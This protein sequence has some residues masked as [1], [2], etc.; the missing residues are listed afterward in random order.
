MKKFFLFLISLLICYLL[1]QEKINQ[2]VNYK[3]L[4][5]PTQKYSHI[6]KVSKE[7]IYQGNL[8]LINK[9][10]KI[11]EQGVKSDIINLFQNKIPD[12]MVLSDNSM[13][14]SKD[15]A[16]NLSKMIDAA[17]LKGINHFMISSGYRNNSKQEKL[18]EEKGSD[19][20][21]PAGFSEHNSGLSL[22]IGSTLTKMDYAPEG[23]WLKQNSWKYG[24]ILRY[25]KGKEDIT[26]I[27]FEPWHF[28]YVGLPHSA[29]MKE[30]NFTLEE[31]LDFLKKKKSLLVN[32]GS[33]KYE[34]YYYP[35]KNKTTDIYL[36]EKASYELSGNNKDG[37]IV[38]ITK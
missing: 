28:R 21:L 12:N 31:Y 29:I 27:Q 37:V 20:A 14:L 35:I 10:L 23:K 8:I 36:P 26:G 5:K 2:D 13:S 19:I 30:N 25:P 4:N 32:I 7:E 15:V 16:L 6:L 18:Y 9:K 1:F 17:E 3:T 38:T 34:I 11:R 24:F 22:D 33:K